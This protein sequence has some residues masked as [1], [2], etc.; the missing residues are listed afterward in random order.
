VGGAFRFEEIDVRQLFDALR[1]LVARHETLRTGFERLAGMSHPLQ[2]I[3]DVGLVADVGV[4]DLSELGV[5]AQRRAVLDWCRA[6]R[7]TGVRAAAASV[8]FAVLRLGPR[9]HVLVVAG[10]SLCID[11]ASLDVIAEEIASLCRGTALDEPLQ[12]ADYCQY[13]SELLASDAGGAGREYWRLDRREA[14]PPRLPLVDVHE[15]PAGGGI[16]RRFDAA[17]VECLDQA[18][19]RTGTDVEAV[20]LSCLQVVVH[21]LTRLSDFAL[22]VGS[23]GRN[24]RELERAIGPFERTT[25][26]SASANAGDAVDA[27]IRSTFVALS[28]GRRWQE[29][30][31]T[32]DTPQQLIAFA[33]HDRRSDGSTAAGFGRADSVLDDSPESPFGVRVMCVVHRTSIEVAI[34][35]AVGCGERSEAALLANAL[36]ATVRSLAP[37]ATVANVD[38]ITDSLRE[39]FR[40][41]N[42]T[43]CDV[44]PAEVLESFEGWTA[45]QPDA[46]AVTAEGAHV[47]YGTLNRRAEALAAHLRGWGVGPEVL[48]G[49]CLPAGVELMRA[50][51][52][53]WKAGGAYVPLDPTYPRDHLIYM[54]NDSAP[55]VVIGSRATRILLEESGCAFLCVEDVGEGA[56]G[57]ATEGRRGSAGTLAYVMYTSGSTGRPKGVMVTQGGL[58]NYV[59][60][61][62]EAYGLGPGTRAAWHSSVSFDLT[63]TSVWGPLASGGCVASVRGEG[64]GLAAALTATGPYAVLKVTPSHLAVLGDVAPTVRQATGVLV[65]GGEALTYAAVRGWQRADGTGTHVVNEY[66]PTETVVGCCAWRVRAAERGTGAVPIGGPIA[67]TQVYVVDAGGGLVPE[68]VVG[69]LWV[70]G[71]GVARGYWG[72][73]RETA[74]RFVPDAYSGRPGARVYRTG[75]EVRWRG[76]ALTYVGRTDGQVKVRG[77]RVEVGEVEAAVQAV[78]GVEAAAVLA[79]RD[80][81]GAVRLVA[82]VAGAV[83]GDEVRAA[84]AR[85]L[86][87]AGVPSAVRLVAAWPLTPNGKVDRAALPRVARAAP[88]AVGAPLQTPVEEVVAQV[89]SAVL[90]TPVADRMAQFFALGGHSLAAAQVVARVRAAL[91]VELS[92]A[93]LFEHPTLGAFA[94]VVAARR[95]AGASGPPLQGVART[96]PLPLSFAQQRLWFLEQLQPGAAYNVPY[97]V[98]VTGPLAGRALRQAVRGLVARHE[99]LRTHFAVQA[100][101]PVQ[102]VAAAPARSGV[103]LVDLTGLRARRGVAAALTRAEAARP[104]ALSTGPLLRVTVLRLAPA[105]HRLLVTLHHIVSDGWSLGVL[106]RDISALYAAAQRGGTAA[107]PALPVQ[108]ADYAVWQRQT[109]QDGALAPALAYWRQHL[110]GLTPLVLPRDYTDA[111]RPARRAAASAFSLPEDLTAAVTQ[112]CR[113][114]DV[115]LFMALLAS[116]QLLLARYS[117]QRDI[118]VGTDVAGRSVVDVE[119]LVGFFVNQIVLRLTISWE[120]TVDEFL[121]RLRTV[122][123]AAYDHQ[124]VPFDRVVEAIDAGR[125]DARG[126]FF[127]IKLVLQTDAAPLA[128][129]DLEARPAPTS[130]AAPKF[131]WILNV[132]AGVGGL[133][134]RLEYDASLFEASRVAW[135]VRF[136]RS[137]LETLVAGDTGGATVACWLAKAEAAHR[138]AAESAYL[139]DIRPIRR[140]RAAR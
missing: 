95:H 3:G 18:A 17:M 135:A 97:A 14:L 49:V 89:W 8:S 139:S 78:P 34:D 7:R 131:E 98:D 82:Y 83:S 79:E 67:Q 140:T 28:G 129:G 1:A 108:Y 127:R 48:V 111:T 121:R 6:A 63:V 134:G 137:L 15:T 115:T 126:D 12:Y 60:W 123:L 2:V 128:L 116:F 39:L 44:S 117:G 81:S 99:P 30:A 50:L 13:Q 119:N 11:A 96:G 94:A 88:R 110:A 69:E 26:F 86:P 57:P 52:A 55:R 118:A 59:S 130:L 109:L 16:R 73:A 45:S 51:L 91:D 103:A 125:S 19:A 77:V 138:S 74:A 27:L 43:S 64:G 93:V 35:C 24:H 31:D 85:R 20:L 104:F 87:D 9:S 58:S 4:G 25:T 61:A 114:R 100:G 90:G 107:L 70:G 66:G 68:G 65:V 132:S 46:V 53:V 113:D 101:A 32:A 112:F 84:V 102:V 133:V 92:V 33:C 36:A 23:S 72:R 38:L 124:D 29:F 54:V 122:T 21:R 62:R 22:L 5:A 41:R 56:P 71:A 75:D 76:G 120:E 10:L 105:Q 47:T 136:Y 42:D 40:S 37:G 106:V 80:A